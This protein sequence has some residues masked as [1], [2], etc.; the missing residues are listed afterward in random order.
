ML[1]ARG[2]LGYHR[3]IRVSPQ[4]MSDTSPSTIV[5]AAI[6][7]I[8]DEILSGRTKDRNIGFIAERL[9]EIGVDLREVRVVP[10]EE[11][12]IVAAVNALR[13]RYDYLFTTG[14][15]GPTHDDITADAIAKAFG[16]TIGYDPR[17][18]A[19]MRQRFAESELNEGRM[20][21]TRIPAGSDLLESPLTRAPGFR[22]GNVFVLPGVPSIMQ[23][24]MDH[25]LPLLKAGRP[26]NS[27]QLRADLLEGD[28]ATALTRIAQE[29]PG[30]IIGSYPFV[31]DGVPNVN[32]L[33]RS[34]EV[35]LLDAARAAVETMLA[36]LRAELGK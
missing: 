20:R 18:V 36:D 31:E 30:A 33:I 15:I 1:A 12:E 9:Y 25:V 5:T 27:V 2:G 35:G 4:A 8:G 19:M 34:R 16:V 29:H 7:V 6:L 3:A 23:S 32:I 10:D 17:A 22:T 28:F 24:M 26:F 14:G 11:D 13:A 21:M